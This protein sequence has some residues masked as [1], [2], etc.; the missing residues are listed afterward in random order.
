MEKIYRDLT[1]KDLEFFYSQKHRIPDYDQ[2]PVRWENESRKACLQLECIRNISYGED[3]LEC[4]D[5]FPAG[6]NTP[7]HI[8]FHGGYWHSQDK[9]ILNFLHCH[10]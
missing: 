7:I 10:L 4:F 3:P 9:D 1:Q 8:F 6:P 2:F 5:L